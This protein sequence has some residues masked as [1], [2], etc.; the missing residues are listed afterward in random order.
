MA[1]KDKIPPELKGQITKMQAHIKKLEAENK[2]LRQYAEQYKKIAETYKTT[3]ER[4]KAVV[5]RAQENYKKIDDSK[6]DGLNAF[7]WKRHKAHFHK[8]LA[9]PVIKLRD[10]CD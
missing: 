8:H 4:Y 9:P 5:Q 1:Q 3:V 2:K 10:L 6:I 7:V